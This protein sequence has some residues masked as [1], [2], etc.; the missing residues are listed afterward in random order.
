MPTVRGLYYETEGHGPPVVLVHGSWSDHQTWRQLAAQ[1]VHI[2][3]VVTYDR[4]GYGQSLGTPP[5]RHEDEVGD[6]IGLLEGLR[7]GPAN[8]VGNS[9]GGT[10]ALRVGLA[11]PDLVKGLALHEPPLMGLLR[12]APDGREVFREQ[13]AVL[14]DVIT[15]LATGDSE[16]GARAFIDNVAFYPGMWESLPPNVR[17]IFTRYGPNFLAEAN[18]PARLEIERAALATL[19]PPLLLTWGEKSPAWLL[20]VE[21]LLHEAV[22]GSRREQIHGAGHV[23][24][25]THAREYATALSGFFSG[26]G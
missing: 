6:L 21:Q 3:Q 2:F 10:I 12:A 24:Q 13:K 14:S 9:I 20:R 19:K 16:G 7:L 4:V 18:D 17:A 22:S 11:R 25:V 8:L 23:P 5:P 26:L 1:L 15:R